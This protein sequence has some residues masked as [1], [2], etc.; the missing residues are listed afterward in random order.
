MRKRLRNPMQ[1]NLCMI[2]I[3]TF[4]KLLN[5]ERWHLMEMRGP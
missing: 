4:D 5:F 3:L 1:L 2:Q